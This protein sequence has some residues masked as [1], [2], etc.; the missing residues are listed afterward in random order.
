MPDRRPQ[1]QVQQHAGPQANNQAPADSEG[2]ESAD[3]NYLMIINRS[4]KPL[5]LMPGEIIFGGQQDR[6]IGQESIIPPGKKAVKIEVYCVESGRWAARD[7][8]ETEAAVDKLA[9]PSDKPMDAKARKELAQEAKKGKFVA[10]AGNLSKDARVA[11]QSGQGQGAVWDNVGQANAASG[12][13]TAS[14][15]FTANY[16]DPK[17]LKKLQAY[18]DKLQR[19]VAEHKQVVGAIVAINGKA[20]AVDVFQ[21][22]PLFEKLWPKLL[23][24]HAL[25]AFAVAEKPEAKK[26]CTPADARDFLLAAMQANVEKNSKG[27]GGL[28]VTKRDSEKVTS[29]SAGFGGMGGMGG[30]FGDSVHSSGY[31]K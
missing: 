13:Q 5:Y 2:L 27:Q 15:A 3:V 14:D 17:V 1:P 9:S 22:T 29:F 6:A 23:K 18:V 24:S 12:I 31:K 8:A 16:T 30:G 28:V 7:D 19:P 4:T 26:V 20:E 10:H 11:V 21:S 25:D